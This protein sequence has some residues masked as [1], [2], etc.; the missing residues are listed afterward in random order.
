MYKIY[1]MKTNGYQL[2]RKDAVKKSGIVPDLEYTGEFPKLE[3]DRRCNLVKSERLYRGYLQKGNRMVGNS[4]L[5]ELKLGSEDNLDMDH[6]WYILSDFYIEPEYANMGFDK[7]LLDRLTNFARAK[8]VGIVQR[9]KCIQSYESKAD[10]LV[11]L[12]EENGFVRFDDRTLYYT[13][14]GTLVGDI[15]PDDTVLHEEGDFEKC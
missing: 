1:K 11:E 12:L 8:K 7:V 9:I 6:K 4:E 15:R 3:I 13:Y 2:V 5:R 14:D 10:S